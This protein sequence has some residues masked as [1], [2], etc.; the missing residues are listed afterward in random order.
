MTKPDQPKRP[1]GGRP[2]ERK[3]KWTEEK[4]K[5][6]ETLRGIGLNQKQIAAFFGISD[7]TLT[8]AK[9]ENPA[10]DLALT[11]GRE[12]AKAKVMEVAY[13]MATS[14][15]N[16][17]MTKFWLQTQAGWSEKFEIKTEQKHTIVFETEL[18]G[19][20]L[21]QSSKELEAEN[22]TVID[23]VIEELTEGMCPSSESESV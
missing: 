14:G 12:K 5:Q 20:R 3:V 1:R 21:R 11:A 8:Y 9:Q 6:A 10:L 2:G 23:A 17:L 19:G 18:S 16:S 13:K 7:V 4:I 15:K 22:V